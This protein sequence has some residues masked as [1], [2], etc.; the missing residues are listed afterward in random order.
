MGVPVTWFIDAQG[1]TVYKQIGLF[2]ST[3]QIKQL[4]KKYF[5]ITA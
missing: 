4:V 2:T 5:G 1:K 3:V